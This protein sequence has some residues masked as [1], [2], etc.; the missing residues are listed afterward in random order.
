[1]KTNR[2]DYGEENN[3]NLKLIVAM[4]RSVLADERDLAGRLSKYGITLS[5]FSVLEPL[6]HLGPMNINSIIEKTLST[7]GNMTVIIRNLEKGGYVTKERDPEDG[8][9]FI[10]SISKKGYDLIDEI[11]PEHI[12]KLDSFFSNL[13]MEEKETLLNLLKKLSG[14]QK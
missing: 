12:G 9:V 10:V 4:R 2:Y 8:R 11:F 6:Y 5:Q 3:L 7:S 1:M 14:Y 13:S